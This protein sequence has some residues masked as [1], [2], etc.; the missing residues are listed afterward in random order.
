M[1]L[2]EKG[3]PYFK[4]T[5]FSIEPDMHACSFNR[6]KYVTIEQD[7]QVIHLDK[8]DIKNLLNFWES[9]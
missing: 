7:D 4:P 9:N 3:L 6:I 5:T 8:W 2:N 1:Q